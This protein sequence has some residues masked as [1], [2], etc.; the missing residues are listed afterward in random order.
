MDIV[1]Q[2]IDQ[3][4]NEIIDLNSEFFFDMTRDTIKH[5]SYAFLMMGI[6]AY[7]DIDISDAAKCLTVVETAT[8]TDRGFD[9][10]YI[11]PPEGGILN[12]SLFKVKYTRNLKKVSNFP[13]NLVDKSI[14]TI[15]SIFDS[16]RQ[17]LLNDKSRIIVDEIRSFLAGG[18]MP[19]V[20]F[21]MINNGIKWSIDAQ[22][23]IDNEFSG[24]KQV[25]F[26]YYNHHDIMQYESKHDR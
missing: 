1:K 17:M 15:K 4:I 5:K 18:V 8:E 13:A 7:L 16:S 26:V 23:H 19:Y 22:N 3:H 11:A 20:T 10:A 21:V 25:E 9:A 6:S 24:H 12:V 14:N 2:I